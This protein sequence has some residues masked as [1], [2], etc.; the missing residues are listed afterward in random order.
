MNIYG[1]KKLICGFYLHGTINVRLHIH[2]AFWWEMFWASFDKCCEWSCSAPS[3]LL[4]QSCCLQTLT[5]P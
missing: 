2:L 1:K 5:L 4:T 3:S